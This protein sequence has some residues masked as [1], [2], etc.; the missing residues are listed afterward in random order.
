MGERLYGSTDIAC[1]AE[2]RETNGTLKRR[3]STRME[4]KGGLLKRRGESMIERKS[5]RCGWRV[6]DRRRRRR[7]SIRVRIVSSL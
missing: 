7:S 1:I 4:E 6:R 5:L 2:I 3:W